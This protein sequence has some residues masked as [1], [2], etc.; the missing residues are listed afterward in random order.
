V[1]RTQEIDVEAQLNLG[2]RALQ[3][4]GVAFAQKYRGEKHCTF[5]LYGDGA[6]NQGQAFKAFNMVHSSHI[7]FFYL[8]DYTRHFI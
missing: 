1:V 2:V 6:S 5:A 4:Q 8:A 3:V 7:S